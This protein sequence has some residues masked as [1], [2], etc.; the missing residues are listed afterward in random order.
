MHRR[1]NARYRP[2][3]ILAA[4]PADGAN[5]LDLGAEEVGDCCTFRDVNLNA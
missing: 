4:G 3:A 2:S 1:F 5:A